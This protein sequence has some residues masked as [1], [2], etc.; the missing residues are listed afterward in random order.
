MKPAGPAPL[1]FVVQPGEATTRLDVLVVALLARAG[2]EASRSAVR[3]W[4]DHGRVLVDGRVAKPAGRVPA[5]S[6]IVVDPEP[7]PVSDA[8]PDPS[9][10]LHVIYEDADLIIID[11]PARIVV[12][13]SRGHESGTLVNAL[14]AHASIDDDASDADDPDG[15]LRPGIV[16]RLDKDTSGVMVVARTARA[17][18][19]LKALFA[20]HDIERE[21]RAIVVG[22]AHAATYDT[23]FGRHPTDR[24]KFSTKARGATRRAVTYVSP[25]ERLAGG[26]ATL[27]SCTLATGRTHQIRVHLS[28]C[29]RTPVLGDKL[30]GGRIRDPLVAAIASRLDRQWLHAAVL[31]FV[32]PVSGARVRF[33]SPLPSELTEAWEALRAIRDA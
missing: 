19:G 9:I 16:H 8:S 15:M 25:V 20:K 4:F 14:L 33:E 21:Y 30:Y 32:H 3:Q 7:P 23:P 6:T 29:G 22:D 2:A 11:K 12:H 27:V 5:G 10:A 17:R 28:E 18:E 1:S 31:G 26:R 24:L 13:P